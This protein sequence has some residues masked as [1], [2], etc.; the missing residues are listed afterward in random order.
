MATDGKSKSIS[1]S[2]CQNGVGQNGNGISM[3]QSNK[4]WFIPN[5]HAILLGG[6]TL[7]L[8]FALNI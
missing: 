8:V 6:Y 2:N 1:L 4:S 7:S 5:S 3:I